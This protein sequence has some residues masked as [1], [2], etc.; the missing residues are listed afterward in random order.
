M[1]LFEYMFFLRF[2][3]SLFI[4]LPYRKRAHIIQM[5]QSQLLAL[6]FVRSTISRVKSLEMVVLVF[7]HVFSSPSPI[8][9]EERIKKK[10]KTKWDIGVG[11]IKMKT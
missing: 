7:V 11:G 1:L 2:K 9:W 8:H 6:T 5:L 10:E 3:G 4:F